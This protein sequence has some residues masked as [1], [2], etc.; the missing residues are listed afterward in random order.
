MQCDKYE[1]VVERRGPGEHI[2]RM[3]KIIGEEQIERR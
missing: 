2:E 3:N 1:R